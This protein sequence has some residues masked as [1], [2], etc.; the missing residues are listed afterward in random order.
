[1]NEC[2]DGQ[3][4]ETEKK[5]IDWFLWVT[6]TVVALGYFY[7]L[8]FRTHN[9][10]IKEFVVT[11]F[12]LMN[13]MSWGLFIGIVFV[14][15][16]EKIPKELVQK[17]MGKGG[18]FAGILRATLAGT[19]LDMC[20]HGILLVGMKMYQRGLSI[21]QTMAF[22]IASPWNSL[23]LTLVLW[24]L[25]GF[26]WMMSFLLF[27]MLIAL[28]SG[29]IFDKLVAAKKLPKNPNKIQLPANYSARKDL[30]KIFMSKNWKLK[31]WGDILWKGLSGSRMVLKWIFFG[32]IAA[33]LMRTFVTPAQMQII[34][35]PT[36]AGLGITLFVATILEICSEGSAPIAAEI[37]TSARAPGNSF[38]FLMTGVS[39]DY[40]EVMSIKEATKSWKIALLLPLITLPQVILLAVIMNAV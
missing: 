17:I 6:F 2:C 30:K 40:T 4:T 29:F 7:A 38:A 3:K 10:Y 33:A 22:L 13:R 31:N 19:L 5:N 11:I 36:L 15:I 9:Q 27:S 26:K 20:S 23:S 12:D 1:M 21:G 28:I 35:G 39:S 32:V 24:G 14:G 16:L 8:F 18:S 25:I 34:F 37:L